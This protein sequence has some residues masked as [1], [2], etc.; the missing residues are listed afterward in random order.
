MLFDIRGDID[1]ESTDLMANRM[2]NSSPTLHSSRS[3]QYGALVVVAGVS[4]A[5]DVDL[6]DVEDHVELDDMVPTDSDS[7]HDIQPIRLPQQP[8]PKGVI[9]SSD[10]ETEEIPGTSSISTHSRRIIIPSA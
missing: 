7:D 9:L 2:S 5:K 8:S 1:P 3:R 6:S 4:S 10:S